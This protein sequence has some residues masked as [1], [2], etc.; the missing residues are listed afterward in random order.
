MP[1]WVGLLIFANIMRI[2]VAIWKLAWN[3][4]PN[5]SEKENLLNQLEAYIELTKLKNKEPTIK[6]FRR[7]AR[8]IEG[9]VHYKDLD[10]CWE[11]LLEERV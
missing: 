8:N 1:L 6:E 3:E 4:Y 2:P 11:Q 5:R 9:N 7:V 10:Q